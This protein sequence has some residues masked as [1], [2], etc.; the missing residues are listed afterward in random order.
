MPGKLYHRADI[1]LGKCENTPTLVEAVQFH[2]VNCTRND[3]LVKEIAY[4]F[5]SA[6]LADLLRN[7]NLAAKHLQEVGLMRNATALVDVCERNP[8]SYVVNFVV[9]EPKKFFLGMKAGVTT[10]GDADLVMNAG[11]ESFGGRGEAINASY[12]YTV[13]GYQSFNVSLSKPFLGWQ[14]YS[15]LSL[16]IYRS[17]AALP[18]NLCDSDEN[19]VV[20]QYNGQLWARKLIHTIKMNMD[21]RKLTPLP[22]AVFSVREHA[23]HTLKCSLENSVAYDTRNNNLLPKKGVLLRLSQEYAGLLGDAAFMKHQFDVQASAPLLLGTILSASVQGSILTSLADRS[24]HVLDRLYLGGPHDLRGFGWNM[25]GTRA[26]SSCLGGATS[27][28]AAL[29]IY[30]PLVPADMLYAHAFAV[31][32]AVVSVRS[33]NRFR[34]MLDAPRVSAGVGLAFVFRNLIRLELNYA[35]PLRYVP[36]D[37]CCPG[38]QFGAGINFL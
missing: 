36:G 12:S 5:K 18:W 13:K 17:L 38:F 10:H 8:H 30:R 16:S 25:I 21:W 11:K 33:R 26:S 28:V 20:L 1:L 2:G 14:K 3:A 37:S 4:L 24:L 7:S 31:S 15:N 22:D 29:H 35:L 27:Y 32:G 6:S 23:G 34:D 19:G 9:E